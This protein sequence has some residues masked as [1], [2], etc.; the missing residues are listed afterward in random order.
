[1]IKNLHKVEFYVEDNRVGDVQRALAQFR[2]LELSAT[3]VVNAKAKGS[4]LEQKHSGPLWQR[5]EQ[6]IRTTLSPGTKITK[7]QVSQIVTANGGKESSTQYVMMTMK[8]NKRPV[9]KSAGRNIL[10]VTKP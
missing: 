5:V 2:V 8:L 1:M 7:D 3:P 4:K 9:V 6:E 10:E